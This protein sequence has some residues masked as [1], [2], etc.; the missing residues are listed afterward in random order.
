MKHYITSIFP[1]HGCCYSC[2]NYA[3]KYVHL[4]SKQIIGATH[5]FP[6]KG[7]VSRALHGKVEVDKDGNQPRVHQHKVGAPEK[8][9]HGGRQA[10]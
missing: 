5:W 10:P 1:N 8:L 2:P 4:F 7:N 6:A 9:D 3:E